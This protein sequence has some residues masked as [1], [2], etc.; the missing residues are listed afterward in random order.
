MAEILVTGAGGKTGLSVIR[1]LA[2]HGKQPRAWVR[3]ETL[4]ARVR[5]Q[6]A[7]ETFVADMRE[8]VGWEQAMD[9]ITAVYHIA[10]NMAVDEE[11]IAALALRAAREADVRHFVYHSVLHPQTEEMPH[12]WK[13]MRVEEA[14]FRADIPF[15]ILQPAPYMQNIQPMWDGITQGVYRLPYATG[16]RLGMV[17]LE[18]VA[19]VAAH[20]LTEPDHR[21][22]IY[23]LSGPDVLDQAEVVDI[24]TATLGRPIRFLQIPRD[25]WAIRA[26]S[27]GLGEYAVTSLVAMFTYYERN[28]LYGNP[29][30]LRMLLGR[31]PHDFRGFVRDQISG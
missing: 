28:G 1:H 11:G 27:A 6:G 30:V 17:D 18:D 31:E 26:R 4:T 22:A 3:D 13:K 29:R 2:R 21:G 12:H 10:P 7:G 19:E 16:T 24:L 5:E 23:E 14:V 20:V 25:E 15:T 8:P 9:G